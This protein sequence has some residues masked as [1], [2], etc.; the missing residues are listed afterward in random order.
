MSIMAINR[1]RL[2]INDQRRGDFGADNEDKGIGL[3]DFL[4]V[5]S[6]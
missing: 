5:V 6:A 4:K 2:L 1:F 3:I